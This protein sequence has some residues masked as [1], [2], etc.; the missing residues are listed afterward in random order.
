V[1]NTTRMRRFLR[2]AVIALAACSH[3]GCERASG[4]L[5]VPAEPNGDCSRE[6]LTALDQRDVDA[7]KD[8]IARGAVAV[9]GKTAARIEQAIRDDRVKELALL[10][11]AGASPNRSSGEFPDRPDSLALAFEGHAF[12]GRSLEATHLLLKHGADPNQRGSYSWN[13]RRLRADDTGVPYTR[14][15]VELLDATPLIAAAVAGDVD[16][17]KALLDSGADVTA[18]D[19]KG[20]TALDYAKKTANPEI[21]TLLARSSKR[22]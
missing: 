16:F 19:A 18:R 3:P 6:L 17:A 10:L 20:Q 4:S 1:S 7:V 15:E 21:L 5:P 9:C 13:L 12:G 22:L 14:Y 11:D 2:C 8:L